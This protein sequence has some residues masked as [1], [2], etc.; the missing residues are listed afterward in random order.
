MCLHCAACLELSRESPTGG[1]F[2]TADLNFGQLVFR[3]YCNRV[4]AE[5]PLSLFV[6]TGKASRLSTVKTGR[7][8]GREPVCRSI[9]S[10]GWRCLSRSRNRI[11]GQIIANTDAIRSIDARSSPSLRLTRQWIKTSPQ[12]SD[13]EDD[14]FLCTPLSHKGTL[15]QGQSLPVE[16]SHGGASRNS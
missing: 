7:S 2:P 9:P 12:V 4:A 3:A 6:N 14:R 11:R 10:S 15:P 8:I 16:F 1:S 13:I 5:L